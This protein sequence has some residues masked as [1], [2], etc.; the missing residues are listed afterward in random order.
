M[1]L[2]VQMSSAVFI[3]KIWVGRMV[4]LLVHTMVAILQ[5]IIM[6]DWQEE[7]NPCLCRMG[8]KLQGQSIRVMNSQVK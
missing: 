6:M 1:K 5:V 8:L 3:Y 2:K 4:T 7:E